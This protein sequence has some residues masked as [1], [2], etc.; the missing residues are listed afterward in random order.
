MD[1]VEL[2]RIALLFIDGDDFNG[3]LIDKIGPTDYDFDKFNRVKNALLK[4]EQIAPELGA[5]AVIWAKYSA[6]SDVVIPLIAGGSLPV[7][8]SKRQIGSA[9]LLGVFD[10]GI[11]AKID[12]AD[13]TS[14]YYS[15]VYDSDGKRVGVFEL[16]TGLAEM[17]DVSYLDMYS[18]RRLDNYIEPEVT[19]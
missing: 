1:V 13:N 10:T 16:L 5:R 7:E 8:G 18:P 11:P 3:A 2:A 4:I 6:E 9:A 19:A 12:R 17:I 15:A 14:S